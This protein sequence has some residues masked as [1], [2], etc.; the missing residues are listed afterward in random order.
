MNNIIALVKRLQISRFLIIFLAGVLLLINTACTQPSSA[1]SATSPTTSNV[2]NKDTNPGYN[3]NY[4]TPSGYDEDNNVV[5]KEVKESYKTV[6]R[7][8]GMNEHQDV[9]RRQNLS[10]AEKKSQKLVNQA[11]DN[12]EDANRNSQKVVKNI[13]DKATPSN[14]KDQLEDLSDNIGK[15]SKDIKE[16]TKRGFENLKTNLKTASEQAADKADLTIP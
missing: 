7:E 1:T 2:S 12:L 5:L 9:D 11:K 14:I 16:G 6:P 15:S 10:S 8:G 3:K 13:Q 4:Q